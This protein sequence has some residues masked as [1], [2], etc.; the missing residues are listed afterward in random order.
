MKIESFNWIVDANHDGRISLNELGHTLL[1][2][3]QIPGNLVVETLGHVPVAAHLFHIQ[4]SAQ[5]GYYSLNS[6]FSFVFSLFFWLYALLELSNLKNLVKEKLA[7]R[8]HH[9]GTPGFGGHGR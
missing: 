4:A 5:A 6:W 1:W 9:H 3:Y 7:Q 2:L 8:H